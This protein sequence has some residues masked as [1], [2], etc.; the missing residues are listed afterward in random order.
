MQSLPRTGA[1]DSGERE[2]G[3]ADALGRP[4]ANAVRRGGRRARRGDNRKTG[5]GRCGPGGGVAVGFKI[6][7]LMRNRKGKPLGSPPVRKRS[8]GNVLVDP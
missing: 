3:Q 4:A 7:S 6:I 8:A 1:R 2:R 5:G